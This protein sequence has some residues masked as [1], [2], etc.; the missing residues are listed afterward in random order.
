MIENPH[1]IAA[2]DGLSLAGKSTMA[3]MIAERAVSAEVVRE[4]TF[5]PH[6]QTTSF[7]NKELKS[8]DIQIAVQSTARQ[9]P[10]SENILH[11]ALIYS[12]N[13]SPEA[14]KQA[15]LAFMF[16]AGRKVVDGHVR[17]AV[18]EKDVILDRWQVTGWA[19][20]VDPSGY[21]W[22]DIRQ[23]NKD[24]GIIDPHLQIILTCSVDQIPLRK[25]YREKEGIG[26]A[27]QMS[28]GKEHIILP[29]FVEIFNA[30]KDVM[31]IEM[32]ENVGIPTP[33]LSEQ[34]KQ[35]VQTYGRIEDL[36]R[37]TG[38]AIQPNSIDNP[39]AFWLDPQRLQ[40]INER[41]IR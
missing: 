11:E 37:K 8:N 19:Y 34:I 9:F 15:L 4:N 35:A 40:R 7:V 14:Q 2:I 38:F 31:L 18:K 10:E 36:L 41:Q 20:Q 3:G 29:A 21:T 24:F 30:L 13:Y 27:G 32:I 25:A 23:L 22:Q 1:R 5:D 6:R 12:R 26:T 39:E 16:T 28:K 17:K 33:D